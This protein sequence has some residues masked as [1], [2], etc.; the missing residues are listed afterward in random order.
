MREPPQ[1]RGQ[2]DT[3]S[4]S[5]L[6]DHYFRHEYGRLVA[7][8]VRRVGLHYLDAVEDAVQ[9]AL[10]AALTVAG[11]WHSPR[12]ER[13]ALPRGAQLPARHAA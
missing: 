6:V 11:R 3:A 8:L 12:S 1:L 10:L 4:P 5:G 9:G 2:R 13:V 7:V